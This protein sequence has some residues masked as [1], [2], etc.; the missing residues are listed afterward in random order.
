MDSMYEGFIRAAE[1]ARRKR[2]NEELHRGDARNRYH[3]RRNVW[4]WR[5]PE[6]LTNDPE[7]WRGGAFEWDGTFDEG[8]HVKKPMKDVPNPYR[9]LGVRHHASLDDIKRV[10]EPNPNSPP[11]STTLVLQWAED[12]TEYTMLT[13][14]VVENTDDGTVQCLVVDVNSLLIQRRFVGSLGSSIPI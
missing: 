1:A 9:V 12:V 13:A 6:G 3:S 8:E 7:Q 2:R 5:K 4:G 10:R 11:R 14:S